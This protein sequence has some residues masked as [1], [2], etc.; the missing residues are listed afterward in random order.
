MKKFF[1]A[2]TAAFI[3]N[4]PA[5]A[6]GNFSDVPAGH[7]AYS[8][9]LELKDLGIINGVGENEFGMGRTLTRAEFAAFLCN[10]MKWEL[11]PSAES[12]FEDVAPEDWF[13]RY[14]AAA[15]NAGAVFA[16]PLFRPNEPITREEMAVMLVRALGCD[17]LAAQLTYLKSPFIDT[18]NNI[19]YINIA[20]D[21]GVIYGTDEN[22]F[23]PSGTAA[24][25][26]AAAMLARAYKIANS[27]IDFINGFY[28]ISSY[29]QI[30]FTQAASSVSFG[31]C[32][33][34]TDE[35]GVTLNVTSQNDNEY[36]IPS[37]YA[38]PLN[39]IGQ[40]TKMMAVF[41]KSADSPLI[42]ENG[43]LRENAAT[44]IADAV[45]N[46][47]GSDKIIFDGATLDFESLSG[48]PQNYSD[49]LASL[50]NKLAPGKLIYVC[51]HPKTP[52]GRK[53]FDGYDY[54]T[55]GEI[56]DK[57]ILMAHDYNAKILT[58]DEMERGTT[59]TPLA[60]VADVYYA[61]KAATETID[62]NKIVLQISL[63]SAQWKLTDGKVINQ[64]PYTPNYAAITERIRE[65]AKINYSK[66]FESPY[67]TFDTPEDSNVIWYEDARSVAAKIKLAKMFGV[68]GISI[69]RLG[70]I[71]NYESEIFL[72]VYQTFLG[73]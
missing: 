38:A 22:N 63:S 9:I 1:L 33:L 10:L 27:K 17:N 64:K 40:K 6:A 24:R 28:A 16:E 69:W 73:E 30:D 56:A 57:V 2:W 36:R 53:Y 39:E 71:P 72:N 14:I 18:E 42:I 15:L 29:S 32:A 4:V 43:L 44:V 47:I 52:E 70:N 58:P 68:Y 41:V 61:L 46:G 60:P 65:G 5:Y 31:W 12:V 25:E 34:E 13:S 62:K 35:T 20:K 19:P 54:K 21:F 55:I 50:K 45:N 23:S 37:D 8:D 67:I 3:L 66:N 11:P 59:V 49:F 48:E 7:W 26:Q 51:V